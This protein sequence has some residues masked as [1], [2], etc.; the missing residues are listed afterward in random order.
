[1]K[2]NRMVEWENGEIE[3]R[4]MPIVCEAAGSPNPP[5]QK[6]WNLAN[7]RT[8]SCGAQQQKKSTEK[9]AGKGSE[10]GHDGEAAHSSLPAQE[11]TNKIPVTM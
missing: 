9:Q 5:P 8:S 2:C 10:K 1:M 4:A 11:H 7:L 6:D 3:T